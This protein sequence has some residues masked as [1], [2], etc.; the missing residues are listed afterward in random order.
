MLRLETLILRHKDGVSLAADLA[1][2]TGARVVIIGPSGAGKSSLLAGIAGFAQPDRGQVFW[3]AL[4]LLPLAPGARPISMI[5]QDNNL[6]PHL[7]AAQ[8]VGLG[9]TSRGR[10]SAAEA[11]LVENTLAQVGLAG[12]GNRKPNA[13]SGGQQSRVAL[14]RMVL[15]DR[16]LVLLDE[17][18]SALGPALR[19]EMLDLLSALCDRTGATVLMVS[20]DPADAMR[21]ASHVIWLDQG[22]A[23]APKPA[24]EIMADPPEAMRAYLGP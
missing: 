20:H 22:R 17:P 15:Q 3:D 13:L 10:L 8:N 6:F 23:H 19:A 4:D 12:F 21:F 14:A 1:V 16:P 11:E 2:P 5:F 24:A 7:T 9:I 18:F